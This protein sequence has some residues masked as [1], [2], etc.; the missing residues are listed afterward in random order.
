M[1]V[2]PTLAPPLTPVEPK[3]PLEP[4]I[5]SAPATEPE[6]HKNPFQPG[7]GIQPEPKDVGSDLSTEEQVKRIM[8]WGWQ[9]NPVASYTCSQQIATLR[10]PTMAIVDLGITT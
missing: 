2:A 9:D 3:K 4:S 5:P 7:P 1:P 8:D 10:T 6:P